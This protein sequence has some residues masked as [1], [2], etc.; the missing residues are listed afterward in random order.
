MKRSR[1]T[2]SICCVPGDV[3]WTGVGCI[4]GFRNTSRKP[5]R[6]LETQSPQLPS[7]YGYR[8]NRDWQY[9][10]DKLATSRAEDLN[11]ADAA[12]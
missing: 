1:T 3:F 10:A 4:H 12:R 11:T 8:F 2:V 7:R 6:W 5:V 9:L